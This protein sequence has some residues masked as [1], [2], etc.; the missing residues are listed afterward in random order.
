MC[1]C[2]VWP[3]SDWRSQEIKGSLTVI[4][5]TGKITPRPLKHEKRHIGKMIMSINPKISTEHPF[6]CHFRLFAPA[7]SFHLLHYHLLMLNTPFSQSHWQYNLNRRAPF[8]ETYHPYQGLRYDRMKSPLVSLT[9]IIALIS[10]LTSTLAVVT[11]GERNAKG[12]VVIFTPKEDQTLVWPYDVAATNKLIVMN[13][14]DKGG[15]TPPSLSFNGNTD[16]TLFYFDNDPV[17]RKDR[18][19]M[20]MIKED[21]QGKVTSFKYAIVSRPRLMQTRTSGK[22]FQWW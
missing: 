13:D 10:S 20:A 4:D 5:P 2:F 7:R 17:G 16:L 1:D 3:Q 8:V 19:D 18:V 21:D 15:F 9:T 14:T 11:E 12:K 22:V 6:Y